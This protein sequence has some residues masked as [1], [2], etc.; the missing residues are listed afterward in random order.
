M[1]T[2]TQWNNAVQGAL[3][4]FY[5][6]VIAPNVIAPVQQQ[7][8]SYAQ[9]NPQQAQ[10]IGQLEP[11]I[12]RVQQQAAQTPYIPGVPVS[13]QTLMNANIPGAENPIT[14]WVSQGKPIVPGGFNPRQAL[15]F[16]LLPLAQVPG[17]I[18]ETL[19]STGRLTSGQGTPMDYLMAAATLS[20]L[21]G[22]A[23]EAGV[24]R[25]APEEVGVARKAIP[26][27]IPPEVKAPEPVG[28]PEKPTKAMLPQGPGRTV[29]R[30][31]LDP[32]IYAPAREA[33][34]Q[35]TLNT[36]V[37]GNT[38]TEQYANLEPTLK[39]F[40]QSI[41]ELNK[42]G[43]PMNVEDLAASYNSAIQDLRTSHLV[44][45]KQAQRDIANYIND[46]Y[47]SAVR[48]DGTLLH[49]NAPDIVGENLQPIIQ[50]A[51]PPQFGGLQSKRTGINPR[52]GKPIESPLVPRPGA[53]ATPA[54]GPMFPPT[55]ISAGPFQPTQP[56]PGFLTSEDL[57]GMYKKA[58]DLN[59]KALETRAA[60][61]PL[62]PTQRV[63]LV[64]R[65]ALGKALAESNP[66]VKDLITKQS[67]LYDSVESLAKQR[68]IELKALADQEAATPKNESTFNKFIRE[69][70]YMSAIAGGATLATGLGLATAGLFKLFPGSL[71]PEAT[72]KTNPGQLETDY[73]QIKPIGGKWPVA[74]PTAIKDTNGVPLSISELQYTQAKE[75]IANYVAAHPNDVAAQATAAAATAKN[76]AMYKPDLIKSQNDLKQAQNAYVDA[77]RFLDN[78]TPGIGGKP[79][80]LDTI[81]VFGL[82]VQ[83]IQANLNPQ[84]KSLLLDLQKIDALYPQ[85]KLDLAHVG[86]V[87]AAKQALDGAM[88]KI[89]SDHNQKINTYIGQNPVPTN[90]P[91]QPAPAN[92]PF[93]TG[94][95]TTPQGPYQMAPPN[96]A[97]QVIPAMQGVGNLPGGGGAGLP[98]LAQQRSLPPLRIP[99]KYEYR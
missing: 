88:Q 23:P 74:D 35:R 47:R 92:P 97:M 43:K 99:Q 81:N 83:Q 31:T 94:Q 9:Q 12:A 49:P 96:P 73:S 67:H 95:A 39:S 55:Q 28:L 66:E 33:E 56:Q 80:I 51:K 40:G 57:Y 36:Y 71:P 48:E 78:P 75:A 38:A 34:V 2:L 11:A 65:D 54:E 37:P 7:I 41:A 21:R 93:S 82:G 13:P 4:S 68:A 44:D 86:S 64:G 91:A 62:T 61:N 89:V 63:Q 90:P 20:G 59:Q 60:G 19:H 52:T 84:Y 14:N 30:V 10:Q 22:K 1:D 76:E 85:L 27:E 18:Q 25:T 17:M 46:L 26:K 87:E 3:P 72:S 16:P 29:T 77:F 6:N 98:P 79:N 69:H 42:T 32:S 24:A 50:E 58:N 45:T 53:P 70:Q 5:K 15:A 8:Q